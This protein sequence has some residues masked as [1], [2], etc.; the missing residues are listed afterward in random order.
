MTTGNYE[1]SHVGIIVPYRQEVPFILGKTP[2][3]RDGNPFTSGI[4]SL[5]RK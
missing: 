2:F 3:H 5:S 1:F 4:I